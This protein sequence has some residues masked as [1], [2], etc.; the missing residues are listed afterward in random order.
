MIRTE[1]ENTKNS[2]KS[3]KSLENKANVFREK[4]WSLWFYFW[5][6]KTQPIGQSLENL[7]LKLTQ[8]IR[9]VRHVKSVMR[10]CIEL[11]ETTELLYIFYKHP[12]I[13]HCT[14]AESAKI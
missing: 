5:L 7:N 4:V 8:Y 11:C 6:K 14:T 9:N 1:S 13:T 2:E 3:R 10:R 12:I